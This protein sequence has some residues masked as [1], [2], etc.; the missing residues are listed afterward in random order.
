MDLFGWDIRPARGEDFPAVC[1]L[2]DELDE[3]HRRARPDLF[4]RLEGPARAPADMA[5]LIAGPD[6]ALFVAEDKAF[7]HLVGL[8]TVAI[9]STPAVAARAARRIAEIDN[10]DVARHARRHGIGR[11]LIRAAQEWAATRGLDTVEL[12]VHEFNAGAIGFYQAVGF[13]PVT[14]RLSLTGGTG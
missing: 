14:R 9:R 1:M 5:A 4:R 11:G 2:F 7:G 10:V 3:L 13:K 12:N 8:V 6:S